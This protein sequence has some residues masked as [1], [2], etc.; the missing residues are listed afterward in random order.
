[1]VIDLLSIE[2]INQYA[3]SQKLS[4][5]DTGWM[6]KHKQKVEETL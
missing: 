6:M 3:D 5:M 2:S 1:M 4:G